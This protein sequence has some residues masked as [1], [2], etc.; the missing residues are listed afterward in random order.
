MTTI[1][2]ISYA[3]EVKNF[4]KEQVCDA[5]DEGCGIGCHITIAHQHLSQLA[6]EDQS[7]YLLH[8]V[9][10]DCR[11]KCFCLGG[12]DYRQDLEAFANNLLLQH[13]DLCTSGEP[14]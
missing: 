1:R 14:A 7:G 6:D 9:M 13:Y 2:S 11:T 4:V 10:A 8:S 12:L 3:D 5:L